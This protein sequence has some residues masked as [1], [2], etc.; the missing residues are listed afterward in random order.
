MKKMTAVLGLVLM[1]STVFAGEC[2]QLKASDSANAYFNKRNQGDTVFVTSAQSGQKVLVGN[3]ELES[4]LKMQF[5]VLG[6]GIMA[7]IGE[8]ELHPGTCKVVKL[9]SLSA[10]STSFVP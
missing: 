5:T 9:R 7:E 6:G 1:S 4:N 8:I 3:S 10:L 2:T